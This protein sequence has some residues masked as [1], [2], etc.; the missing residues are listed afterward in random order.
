MEYT[1]EEYTDI[2]MYYGR[3]DGNTCEGR[4]IYQELYPQ[5][6]VPNVK[7][8]TRV[9]QRLRT[10]C[11]LRQTKSGGYD[12]RDPDLVVKI[13]QHIEEDPSTSTR[14]IAAAEGVSRNT[15]WKILKEQQMHPYHFQ[16]V[17]ALE[18]GNLEGRLTFLTWMLQQISADR[19]FSSKILFT[20]KATFT[21]HGVQNCYNDHLWATKNPRAVVSR[22][23]SGNFQLM[24]GLELS[25]TKLLAQLCCLID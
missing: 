23:R 3:A 8:F 25:V 10:T 16:R 2:H 13:M 22:T 4:R 7:T 20:D 1:L 9:H 11:S 6:K 24:F 5:L 17:Q 14:A 19:H 12:Q 21:K 15:V 18:A